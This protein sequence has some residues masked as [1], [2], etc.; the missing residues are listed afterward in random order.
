MT[1]TASASQVRLDA[2]KEI[3]CQAFQALDCNSVVMLRTPPTLH[4]VSQFFPFFNLG[5]NALLH[6]YDGKNYNNKEFYFF[7]HLSCALSF[8]QGKDSRNEKWLS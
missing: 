8:F 6:E 3:P 5:F 4:L 1:M 7:L 2:A